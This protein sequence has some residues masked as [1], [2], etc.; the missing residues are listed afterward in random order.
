MVILAML[1]SSAAFAGVAEELNLPVR[2]DLMSTEL[3]SALEESIDGQSGDELIEVIFQFKSPIT[4]SQW[5]RIDR[6]D[7]EV[8]GTTDV[9]NGGLVAGKNEG[10]FCFF[11]MVGVFPF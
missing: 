2:Y 4:E 6:F 5:E 8:L 9:I 10:I 11:S 3:I 1:L 7:L